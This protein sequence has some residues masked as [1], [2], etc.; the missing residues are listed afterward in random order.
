ML[1]MNRACLEILGI[2]HLKK[3]LRGYSIY[4]DPNFNASVIDSIKAG[5]ITGLEIEYD[6]DLIRKT[7][8]YE[9]S[10]KKRH[11]LILQSAL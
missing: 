5:E 6:F 11:S 4:D 9:T 10:R 1:E 2:D 3:N 7:G 8:Y